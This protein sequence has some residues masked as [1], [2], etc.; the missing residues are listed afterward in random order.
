M[1]DRVNFSFRRKNVEKGKEVEKS[2][3]SVGANR[4]SAGVAR[5]GFKGN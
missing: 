1:T 5:A 2:D 4:L 3:Q